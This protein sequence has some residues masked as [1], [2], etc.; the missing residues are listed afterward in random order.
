MDEYVCLSLTSHPGE[1]ESDFKS[2]LTAFW[3]HML[4]TKPDDYEKVYAEAT[5]FET[6]DSTLVRKYMVEASGIDSLEAELT[7]KG[8]AFEPSDRDDLFSKYEAAPPDWFWIEH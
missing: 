4:R 5:Q 6:E 2:R 1:S 3:T 7:A 8:I